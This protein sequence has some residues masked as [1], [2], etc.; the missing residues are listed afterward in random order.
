MKHAKLFETTRRLLLKQFDE[1][2]AGML[3]KE[4]HLH[5]PVDG[6][7]LFHPI[8]RPWRELVSEIRTVLDKETMM[9][10][11]TLRAENA[12]AAS[13]IPRRTSSLRIGDRWIIGDGVNEE[14]QGKRAVY[15]EKE[16]CPNCGSN[17]CVFY[18]GSDEIEGSLHWC[19]VVQTSVDDHFQCRKCDYHWIELKE[20]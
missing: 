18:M 14:N 2:K 20:I 15:Q 4:L 9:E 16:V 7:T 19:H 17:N 1:P 3:M 6:K 8:P 5:I 11:A 13:L 12:L 10:I